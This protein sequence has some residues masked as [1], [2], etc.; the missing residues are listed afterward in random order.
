[1]DA[2]AAAS[3]KG[4]AGDPLTS[5][6]EVQVR[7]IAQLRAALAL[8]T[9]SKDFAAI[10]VKGLQALVEELQPIVAAG[11]ATSFESAL[12]DD[13]AHTDDYK[14]QI[15]KAVNYV[16]YYSTW[17]L[18]YLVSYA[19]ALACQQCVNFKD[20]ALQFFASDA[21]KAIQEE[22]N[23]IFDNLPAPVP[24]CG[25][26]GLTF[27]GGGYPM[28]ST[29]N[30]NMGVF[31]NAGGTC[32]DQ[33]AMI[34]MADGGHKPMKDIVAGEKVWGGHTIRAVVR[35]VVNAR[36][37]MVRMGGKRGGALITPWHPV[38][39][40]A[41]GSW[42]FPAEIEGL[43]VEEFPMNFYYNMVLESGHV[44]QFASEKGGEAWEA[45]TLGH[46][47]TDG[48]VITHPYFGTEAV[49]RDLETARG[50]SEGLVLLNA[51]KHVQRDPIT[52]LVNGLR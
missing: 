34:R 25:G 41:G 5:E 16:K 20:A 45:C 14:G 35:T 26:G 13:L 49:V 44:V 17:G 6:E 47:F 1:V 31:N 29:I 42:Q 52:G 10:D 22:G 33:W 37:P 39:Q 51:A 50:W 21:F 3:C 40:G 30:L 8:A 19:R 48:P 18:N 15:M 11:A 32:W 38:R 27:G 43:S 12:L 36:V 7:R 4:G 9:R 2:A 28:L 46:G 23:D 24:S